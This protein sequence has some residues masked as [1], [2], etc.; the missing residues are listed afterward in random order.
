[1]RLDSNGVS[2]QRH[3]GLEPFV[4]VREGGSRAEG[5]EVELEG[6]R[7]EIGSG[8]WGPSRGWSE[9]AAVNADLTANQGGVGGGRCRG[10]EGCGEKK[11]Q[12]GVSCR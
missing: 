3:E 2:T 5:Q 6:G 11:K 7:L 9:N 1:M 10:Q 8:P 12:L 4:I